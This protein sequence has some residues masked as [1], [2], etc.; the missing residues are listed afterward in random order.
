MVALGVVIATCL[1]TRTAHAHPL[2][3][4]YVRLD[5]DEAGLVGT[6]ARPS[7]KAAR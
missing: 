4:S 7:I 2:D 3:M 1:V 5:A 6:P